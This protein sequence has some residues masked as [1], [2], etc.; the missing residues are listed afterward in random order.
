MTI[1]D[2][3]NLTGVITEITTTKNGTICLIVVDKA[4]KGM[5]ESIKIN[6]ENL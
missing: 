2:K 3:V 4:E 1:G 6:I 5:F